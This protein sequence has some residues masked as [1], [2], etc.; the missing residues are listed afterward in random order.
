MTADV[1]EAAT[2]TGCADPALRVETVVVEVK[3]SVVERVNAE[4]VFAE[5]GDKAD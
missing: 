1:C 3:A 2:A 5:A 4:A